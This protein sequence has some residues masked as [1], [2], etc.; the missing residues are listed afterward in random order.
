MDYRQNAD[1]DKLRAEFTAWLDT[2]IRRAKLDYL[3]KMEI[4][5]DIVSLEELGEEFLPITE[6]V[7]MRQLLLQED[8][9]NFEEER[10]A[11]AYAQLP[12]LRKQILKLLFVDNLKVKEVA[13]KLN[14]PSTYVSD[15]KRRA[16]AALRKKLS[17]GGDEN[18]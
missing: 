17:E 1:R 5:V 12:L 6:D 11:N 10:L 15:Q 2:L 18:G 8:D 16:L 3:R 13:K 7:W 14:C 9:F 4:P